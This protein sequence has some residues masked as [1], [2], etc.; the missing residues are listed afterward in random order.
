MCAVGGV[1]SVEVDLDTKLAR[2]IGSVLDDAAV[3]RAIN[4][5][6]YAAARPFPPERGDPMSRIRRAWRYLIDRPLV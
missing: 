1:E 6:G 2:V 5:A 4:E 3:R